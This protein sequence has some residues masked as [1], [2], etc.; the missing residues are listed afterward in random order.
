M[1]ITAVPYE[2]GVSS[3][4]IRRSQLKLSNK[5]ID[6]VYIMIKTYFAFVCDFSIS[7]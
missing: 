7:G 5:G 4:N 3:N 2:N 1:N 6:L